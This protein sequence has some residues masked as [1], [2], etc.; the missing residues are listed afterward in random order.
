[1]YCRILILE[2]VTYDIY[3]NLLLVTLLYYRENILLL[4]YEDL[5]KH[6]FREPVT[7]VIIWIL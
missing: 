4:T 3:M 7:I 2:P 6:Y 5:Y 1:M